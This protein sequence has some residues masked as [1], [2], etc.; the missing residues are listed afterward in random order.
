MFHV[1]FYNISLFNRYV[2]DYSLEIS[3][4]KKGKK[5]EKIIKNKQIIAEQLSFMVIVNRSIS[6]IM[7]KLKN[8]LSSGS[9][10]EF[11]IQVKVF[12]KI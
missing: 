3:F 2:Y 4:A 10:S 12:L 11:F 7:G 1:W 8:K 5:R 9:I 6:L